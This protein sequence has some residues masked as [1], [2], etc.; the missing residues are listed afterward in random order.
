MRFRA[1]HD[2]E[3]PAAE[4]G[5]NHTD[6][7]LALWNADGR[8]SLNSYRVAFEQRSGRSFYTFERLL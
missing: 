3:Y 7:E 6:I 4:L 1:E 5:S 8:I 2:F